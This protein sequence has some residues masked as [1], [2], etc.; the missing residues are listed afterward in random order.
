M[1]GALT[2]QAGLTMTSDLLQS[3]PEAS[4]IYTPAMS[5][6]MGALQAVRQQGSSAQVVTGVISHNTDGLIRNHR[7]LAVASEPGILIGRLIVQYAIRKNEGRPL[8][9]VTADG[10]IPYPQF[11]VPVRLLQRENL[12]DYPY[13]TFDLPPQAW[14]PLGLDN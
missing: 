3:Y 4:Y 14:S 9:K 13:S 8:E 5:T 11:T 10:T 7:L 1:G 6:A 2:L 12:N